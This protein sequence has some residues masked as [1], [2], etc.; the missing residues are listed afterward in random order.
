MFD[1]IL[2]LAVAL[3]FV[4][5][6]IFMVLCPHKFKDKIQAN[7]LFDI[8]L[9]GIILIVGGIFFSAHFLFVVCIAI[10]ILKFILKG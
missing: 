7:S 5:Y 2:L 6:G 1:L 8:R 9:K 3:L 10:R 4:G